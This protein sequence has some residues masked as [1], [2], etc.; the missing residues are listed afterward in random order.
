MPAYLV[1]L[2]R[3]KTGR[4]LTDGADAMVIFASSGTIAKQ[5]AA[6]KNDGEGNAW[7]TDGTATEIVAATN[8]LGWTFRAQLADV[9]VSVTSSGANDTI[10]E[11]AALLV[12]AL[13][14]T[15]AIANAAYNATTN[16][17]TVAGTADAL[18]DQQLFF[19]ITPPSGKSEVAGLVGAVVDGGAEADAVTVTLPADA[20]VVPSVPTS[21]VQV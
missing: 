9:D 17:L 10:D 1:T 11:I 7:I 3:S 5:V 19:T 12:T 15:A 4:T 20:A 2:D 16:V 18:G 13:N 8:W 14:A 6:A 21:L